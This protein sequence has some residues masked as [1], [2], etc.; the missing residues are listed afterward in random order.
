ME[1]CGAKTRAGTPCKQ[2]AGWGTDHVGEGRC[3][4]HGGKG[5]GRPIIHG[6]YSFKHKESLREKQRIFL[7]DPDA[8]NLLPELALL[9]ALLQDYLDRLG[10]DMKLSHFNV[11]HVQGLVTDIGRHVERIARIQN[12]TALTIAEVQF[13]QVAL[14]EIIGKYVPEE[15]L[16]EFFTELRTYFDFDRSIGR[17]NGH[18]KRKALA[19]AAAN[20][21]TSGRGSERAAARSTVSS[22]LLSQTTDNEAEEATG[23]DDR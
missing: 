19:V 7:N 2:K 17:G 4:L 12:Q 9:R 23:E 16:D 6:R 1:T 13:I 18:G 22:R 20:R 14:K 11:G 21:D 10:D 3:K 15:R 8:G 5:S